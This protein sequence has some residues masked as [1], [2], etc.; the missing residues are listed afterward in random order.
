MESIPEY[1]LGDVNGDQKV[2]NL[3]VLILQKYL[4][5]Q[6]TE[7]NL[8]ACDCNQDGLIDTRDLLVLEEMVRGGQ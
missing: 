7:V 3:D 8:P 5:D 1:I 4:N 2:N 6:S